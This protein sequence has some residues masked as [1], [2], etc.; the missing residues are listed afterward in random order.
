MKNGFWKRVSKTIW[1]INIFS[2][3]ILTTVIYVVFTVERALETAVEIQI[4]F[5]NPTIKKYL[6][7]PAKCTRVTNTLSKIYIFVRVALSA[8]MFVYPSILNMC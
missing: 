1:K 4:I 3:P 8:Q 6:C 7:N 5:S 2:T